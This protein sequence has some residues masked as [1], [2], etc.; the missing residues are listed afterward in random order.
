[1]SSKSH[2]LIVD[3]NLQIRSLLAELL[4]VA[5]HT[6]MMA[7]SCQEAHA[8]LEEHTFN[9]ALIDLGLPDGNGLD[10]LPPITQHHPLLVPI[11]LTGDGRAE[12]IIDT[13]RAGAFDFLIKPFVSATLQAA[14]NR[15]LDYHNALRE[16][17]ELVQ[18]LSEER[19]QLKIRVDDATAD[20]RQYANHCKRVGSRLHSLV[21]LT[22]VASERYTDELVFR[23]I[24]EELE[25]YFPLR[26]VALQSATGMEFLCARRDGSGE[27]NVI[28]VEEAGQPADNG[29]S[30]ADMETRIREMA[31]R[32]AA[33]ESTGVAVYLYPQSYWGK[34][35]CTVAFFLEDAFTVDPECDQFLSMCA[36]FLGFEWQDARL[37]LHATQQASLGNIAVE[38]SKG[39]IQ[40]LT[41]IRTTADF[42]SETAV[43]AEALEGL[44]L[45]RGSVD[46]LH[47]QIKNFRQLSQPHKDSVETVHLADYLNQAVDMLGRTIKNKGIE[48]ERYFD[49]DAP[50][51]LLNGP[52]L[53]RTFLDLISA[54]V[55]AVDV[56]GTIALRL[57]ESESN[58]ALVRISYEI[59]HTELFGVETAAGGDQGSLLVESH[60]QF[61][62][63]QRSVQSCGGRLM[64]KYEDEIFCSFHIIL[65]RNPLSLEP[66]TE[67]DT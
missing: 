30:T 57:S 46:S 64:L 34:K 23:S 67:S 51:V 21:R 10:L 35:A 49:G 1:M 5:G 14:V 52:S 8:L 6:S 63:A 47:V 22:Q 45:I 37:S 54:A 41:A 58:H 50:C 12:T 7:S 4:S 59:G 65:P 19:E 38:I 29:R 24:V 13:M 55:R 32:H 48:V 27:I 11:I 60:P 53:A 26:C 33:V 66:S 39:L 17:D 31:A 3:D 36:H 18:L 15:A 2:I 56:D 28:A 43:S 44:N 20:L 40:D 61:I 9:C 62:L 42:I 25:N 16:R